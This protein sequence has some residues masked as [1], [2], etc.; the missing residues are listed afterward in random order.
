MRRHRILIVDEHD[1][2]QWG[3]RSLLGREPWVEQCRSALSGR[4]SLEQAR[5]FSPDI[6]LVDL[7]VGGER[8]PDIAAALRRS[9]DELA[10]VYMGRGHMTQRAIRAAG[11]RGFVSKAAAAEH[12]VAG[13][14]AALDHEPIAVTA[15]GGG[16][17]LSAREQDVLRLMADGATNREIAAALFLAPDTVKQHTSAVYRKL[18]VRNRIEAVQ[19]AQR[20]ELLTLASLVTSNAA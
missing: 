19:Q 17:R 10:I 8:G 4:A 12:F 15:D 3:L 5:D 1:I 11:G 2:V 13:V 9:F 20:L 7:F 16:T 14:R 18:G 6:A